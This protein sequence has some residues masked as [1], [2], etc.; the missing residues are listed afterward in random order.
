M[1]NSSYGGDGTKWVNRCW[2]AE[3]KRIGCGWCK[4]RTYWIQ[5]A[6]LVFSSVKQQKQ[7]EFNTI[8]RT[9]VEKLMYVHE[10]LICV[11]NEP[12]LI[13]AA[14]VLLCRNQKTKTHWL[15][16]I[17]SSRFVVWHYFEESLLKE[18]RCDCIS[19]VNN[20]Q[21]H[22]QWQIF[23]LMRRFAKKKWKIFSQDNLL[24]RLSSLENRREICHRSFC[25]GTISINLYS[26]VTDNYSSRNSTDYSISLF[27]WPWRWAEW[28][29]TSAF[30]V[31]IRIVNLLPRFRMF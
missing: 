13:V 8:W 16:E 24:L 30:D 19:N 10:A 15:E 25:P 7:H 6:T 5:R 18:N 14:S 29:V 23:I 28:F 12:C 27:F 3:E 9:D 2:R 1:I 4:I 26:S 20:H 17:C 22:C 31:Q 21:G 11:H